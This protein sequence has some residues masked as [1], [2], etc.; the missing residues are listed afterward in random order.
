MAATDE[1]KAKANME[2]AQ[3]RIEELEK[4]VAE[5]VERYGLTEMA[6]KAMIGRR[7]G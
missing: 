1:E 4:A 7:N 3:R 2:A 6:R 5:Y